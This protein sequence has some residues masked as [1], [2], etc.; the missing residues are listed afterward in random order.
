MSIIILI[1]GN[2]LVI[3]L[4]G[5]VAVIQAIRLNLYELG[6]KFCEC[7]GRPFENVKEYAIIKNKC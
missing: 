1:L 2:I 7:E 6:G 5:F 4:E 3:G